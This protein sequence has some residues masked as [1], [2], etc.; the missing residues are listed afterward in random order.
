M[1]QDELEKDLL[2]VP[3]GGSRLPQDTIGV[4]DLP[5]VRKYLA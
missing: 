2:E 4:D 5:S 3:A 1:E